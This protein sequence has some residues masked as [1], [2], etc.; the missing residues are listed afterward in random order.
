MSAKSFKKFLNEARKEGVSFKEEKVKG[1][2]DK[3]I[4]QLEGTDAAQL[5]KVARQYHNISK[6]L[7]KLDEKKAELNKSLKDMVGVTFDPEADK[8]YT[9]VLAS[10]KFAATLAKENKPEDV[11]EKVEIEY[12]RLV[13]GLKALL[14]ESLIPAAD[15]L[16]EACTKRWKP[17]PRSP[18]L[19]VKPLDEAVVETLASWWR[20]AKTSLAGF[21][22]KFD[23]GLPKLEAQLAKYKAM[24]K[25]K[26]FAKS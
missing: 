25:P 5:T 8:F 19:T 10:T 16:V 9:R 7:K 18:N 1:A 22:A 24:P 23:K 3:V 4:A 20:A 15:K 14:D 17:E 2:V 6:A 12:E 21:L 26:V 13:E 11:A